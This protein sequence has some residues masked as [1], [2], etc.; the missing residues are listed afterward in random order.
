MHSKIKSFFIFVVVGYEEKQE[1]GTLVDAISYE[2]IAETS[3]EAIAK[4]KGLFKKPFYRVS[5]IIEK[6]II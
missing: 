3:D 6:E 4:A 1:N 2:V 5:Q